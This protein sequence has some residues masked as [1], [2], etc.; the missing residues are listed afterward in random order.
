MISYAA[1]SEQEQ[2]SLIKEFLPFIKYTAYR[3]AWRLPAHLTAEDLISVGTMGLLDALRRYDQERAKL[4]TF[5]EF[6]IKGAMLDEIRANDMVP[7]SMKKKIDSIRKTHARL[8]S[9]LFRLPSEEEIADALG[10]SVEEYHQTLQDANNCIVLR[11]EEF[12]SNNEDG[13]MDIADCL[14]DKEAKNPLDLLED[15]KLKEALAGAIDRLPEKE[16]T[17]LSLY[18]WDELTMKE[19]AKVL[20]LTEG[21]VSQ[22]HKQALLRLKTQFG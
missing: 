10:I 20:D 2:E 16:K 19:I 11:F 21:R 12:K 7:K 17:I 15:T 3:L 18:Y 6:R 8:E 4:K 1:M 13:E 22:L 14:T 5:V 9:E